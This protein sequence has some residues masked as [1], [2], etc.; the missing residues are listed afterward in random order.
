MGKLKIGLVGFN[1]ATGIGSNCKRMF[2]NLPIDRWLIPEHKTMAYG[3]EDTLPSHGIYRLSGDDWET[4]NAF[5]DGLNI[6]ISYERTWPLSLFVKAKQKGIK[7]ILLCNAEWVNPH[8]AAFIMA[9]QIII[10][11]K[12]GLNHLIG[13]GMGHK[14]T[15]IPCPVDINELPFKQRNIA[16]KAVF[17]N[18]LGGVNGR[19]GLISIIMALNIKPL[20]IDIY[21]INDISHLFKQFDNPIYPKTKT[22]AEFYQNCDIAI[23]PSLYEGTGLS[24]LEALASGVPCITTDYGPM[25]EYIYGAYGDEAKKFLLENPL[26]YSVRSHNLQ[27]QAARSNPAEI[28]NKLTALIDTDI[29]KYSLRAR[30]YIE[31]IHGKTAWKKLLDTITS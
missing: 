22:I 12:H 2:K 24:I 4:A 8:E 6:V 9:D 13:L 29:S 18:G 20:P 30:E 23:Q 31:D 7:T 16:K 1:T 25:N 11:T 5:L 21:S 19:K 28:V 10:R 26:F 27:W 3:D 17:V 14:T 15:F